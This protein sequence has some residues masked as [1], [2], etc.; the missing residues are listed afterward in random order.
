MGLIFLDADLVS[1]GLG[2][3]SASTDVA[4]VTGGFQA[5]L[6]TRMSD[7]PQPAVEVVQGWEVT[8][9]NAILGIKNSILVDAGAL[10]DVFLPLFDETLRVSVVQANGGSPS[11]MALGSVTHVY[12][13]SAVI[14]EGAAFFWSNGQLKLGFNDAYWALNPDLSAPAPPTPPGEVGKTIVSN[15]G[16][17][18][19][20]EFIETNY[21]RKFHIKQL[22]LEHDGGASLN[23]LTKRSLGT[24]PQLDFLEF[25]FLDGGAYILLEQSG[26]SYTLGL[27]GN[28]EL[29][30][31]LGGV[32]ATSRYT[33]QNGV[34][35]SW[36][37]EGS[38]DADVNVVELDLDVAGEVDLA[39]NDL[40]FSAT[41]EMTIEQLFALGVAGAFGRDA[42][43]RYWYLYAAVDLQGAP[44]IETGTVAFYAFKGGVAHHLDLEVNGTCNILTPLAY[45]SNADQ[46]VNPG[47]N[48]SFL[49]GTVVAPSEAYGGPRTVHVDG[50][51]VISSEGSVDIGRCGSAL[52]AHTRWRSPYL[53]SD[54]SQFIGDAKRSRRIRGRS[55]CG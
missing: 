32:S 14:G 41:G 43:T 42:G 8:L 7:E 5:L 45:A 33:V 16:A 24:V 27:Q 17:T 44:M 12:G 26:S 47:N 55:R 9:L 49:A 51:L 39:T 34:G 54:Q 4:W 29:A 50:Q 20:A 13:H 15:E 48:W 10:A 1:P 21:A 18:P 30:S 22:T 31:N 19:A 53:R 36:T 2:I 38:L 3:T 6:A 40:A 23:G 25:P 37:F 52:A 35:Q 28:L 46:C 11:I